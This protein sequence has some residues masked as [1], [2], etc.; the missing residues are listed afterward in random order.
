[1]SLSLFKFT[2]K[3]WPFLCK[4]SESDLQFENISFSFGRTPILG[5]TFYII[6]NRNEEE[7]AAP[8][9]FQRLLLTRLE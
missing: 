4:A 3:Y 5:V 7:G 6:G 9:M 8:S 2:F 1:M